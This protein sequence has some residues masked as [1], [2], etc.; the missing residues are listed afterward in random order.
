MHQ[1]QD[2]KSQK[3]DKT[4]N[5]HCANCGETGSGNYCSKCGQKYLDLQRPVS[6]LKEE[7]LDSVNIDS[8]ILKT[9]V[10]FIIKPGYLAKEYLE[11]KRKRFTSPIRLYLLTSILF[12]FLAQISSNKAIRNNENSNF[13]VSTDTID[14]VVMD[15]ASAIELLKEDTLVFSEDDIAGGKSGIRKARREHQFKQ[16]LLKA[17]TEKDFFL[18]SLYKN[19]SYILFILMPAFALILKLL[20]IRRRRLYIEHLI[21]SLNMH[22]FSLLLF[23]LIVTLSLIFTSASGGFV[24]LILILPLYYTLGMKR[25]YMQGWGKTIAKEIILTFI[26]LILVSISLLTVLIMTLLTI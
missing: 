14:G 21:F 11:G 5:T 19:I 7:L 9:I 20:Y 26:Y 8:R 12:F 1:S 25:F 17:F 24:W 10:P 23:S 13:I 22:S 18:Q 6:D 2:P 16:A 3:E 4:V 15:E